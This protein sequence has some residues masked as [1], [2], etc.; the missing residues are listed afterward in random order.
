MSENRITKTDRLVLIK[1][2]RLVD[3]DKKQQDKMSNYD[4][5][6]RQ[7]RPFPTAFGG[8]RERDRGGYNNR[9]ARGRGRYQEVRYPAPEIKK[10]VP[11]TVNVTSELDFPSLATDGWTTTKPAICPGTSSFA[12]LANKWKS[13]EEK[14]EIRIKL[15]KEEQE[16]KRLEES[17]Y[18][19]Q[20][21]IL[22]QMRYA[23][24]SAKYSYGDDEEDDDDYDHYEALDRYDEE[25]KRKQSENDD[26]TTV[27]R[28]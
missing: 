21:R 9:G 24:S 27:E 28:R 5:D 7:Q 25:M 17:R 22:G 20:F 6:S 10:E 2:N 4:D 15:E 14:E 16:K 12:T 1:T 11:K 13:D 3:Y 26:W 8:W 19:S 23:H 18:N